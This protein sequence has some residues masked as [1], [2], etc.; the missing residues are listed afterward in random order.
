MARPT[1]AEEAPVPEHV[2]LP[3][4]PTRLC[5][6][7]AGATGSPTRDQRGLTVFELPVALSISGIRSGIAVV[8]HGNALHRARV[9]TASAEIPFVGVASEF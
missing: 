8:G 2:P 1:R 3:R 6:G 7:R 4:A 9:A 5:A